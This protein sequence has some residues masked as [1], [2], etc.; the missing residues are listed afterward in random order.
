MVAGDSRT[1]YNDWGHVADAMA[2]EKADFALF[3]GD[4]MTNFDARSE[5]DSWT[6]YGAGLLNSTFVMTAL[7]NHEDPY[8]NYLQCFALPGNERYYSFNYSS[9]H[10][11]VLDSEVPDDYAQLRW[12]EKD[13]AYVKNDPSVEWTF[14]MFH[15][16]A[17]GSGAHFHDEVTRQNFMPVLK[18]FSIDLYFYGHNHFYQRTFPINV[19]MPDSPRVTNWNKSRYVDPDP[20]HITAGRAGAPG[21]EPTNETG[22]MV[23]SRMSGELHY[24]EINVLQNHSVHV[25]AKYTDGT[26]F[27]D[28]WIETRL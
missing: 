12:V 5:W 25:K 1:Y 19:S 15:R 18:N 28:F 6:H 14:V 16:P 17:Y 3:S 8:A 21:Y 7:G 23:G 9:A 22:Y 10:V 26:P 11:V 20:I 24:V 27:D 2:A 13:L 4:A